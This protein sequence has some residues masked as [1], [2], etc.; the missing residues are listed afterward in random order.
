MAKKSRLRR[1]VTLF[2]GALHFWRFDIKQFTGGHEGFKFLVAELTAEATSLSR[3]ERRTCRR[4]TIT[5]FCRDPD[6]TLKLRDFRDFRDFRDL[7]H[8]VQ[9]V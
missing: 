1:Q 8:I 9:N 2:C 7:V 4:I 3:F 5:R 6:L